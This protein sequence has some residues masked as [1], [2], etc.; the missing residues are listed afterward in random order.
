MLILWGLSR[1]SIVLF[2]F[3]V[4]GIVG[5]QVDDK[6]FAKYMIRSLLYL[7][8]FFVSF[9]TI[10][11]MSPSQ[12]FWGDHF[13]LPHKV[14]RQIGFYH[15]KYMHVQSL[16]SSNFKKIDLRTAEYKRAFGIILDLLSFYLLMISSLL[17]YL[18]DLQTGKEME[19]LKKKYEQDDDEELE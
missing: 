6:F 8:F 1:V 11:N 13:F 7:G 4:C 5:V 2:C 12:S 3:V 16:T 15:Y 19:R 14:L 9:Q 18:K 17:L 10:Y